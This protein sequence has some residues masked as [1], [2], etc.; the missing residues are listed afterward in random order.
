[1]KLQIEAYT[2]FLQADVHY[3]DR[4]NVGLEAI[5]REIFP[6]KSYDGKITLTYIGYELGRPRYSPQECRQL[7]LTYG[8]PFKVRVRL[9][10]EEPVEEEVYLGELPIMVGGGEFIINGAERVIV[11]QLHRSPGVDFSEELHTSEKRLHSCRIIPER[12]SWIEL[13]VTKKDALAIR[14]DQSGKFSATCFLRAMAEEFSSNRAI[15]ELFYKV[16]EVKLTGDK[17]VTK[18]KGKVS[19]ED[20]IDE[21]SGEVL[22]ECGDVITETFAQGLFTDKEKRQVGGKDRVLRVIPGV[23]DPLLLNTLREDLSK[24]H[25]DAL[26]RIYQRLRPGEWDASA[27]TANSTRRFRRPR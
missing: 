14:I 7:R 9:E 2:R 21:A 26:I 5:L 17:W 1:M 11:S 23:R 3:S 25:E 24:N 18:V 22:L 15:V 12:G 16:D 10:K 27:L 13:N 6:I 8:M 4:D 19:A 20:I